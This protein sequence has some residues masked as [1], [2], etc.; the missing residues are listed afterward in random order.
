MGILTQISLAQIWHSSTLV[1]I[2]QRVCPEGRISTCE[3]W[4]SC[5]T[6]IPAKIQDVPCLQEW[7]GGSKPITLTWGDKNPLY[8][9]SYPVILCILANSAQRPYLH[10]GRRLKPWGIRWIGINCFWLLIT[11]DIMFLIFQTMVW[12]IG[13][14]LWAYMIFPPPTQPI[15]PLFSANHGLSSHLNQAKLIQECT[16]PNCV[17]ARELKR[18]PV[19]LCCTLFY[20]LWY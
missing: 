18:L 11:V 8:M 5:L 3:V 14:M 2:H 13:N 7:S 16:L 4:L 15:S 9:K 10:V 12:T 1:W 6:S 17:Q 20:M 19:V